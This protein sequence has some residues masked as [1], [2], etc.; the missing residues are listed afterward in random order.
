MRREEDSQ[1]FDGP[2]RRWTGDSPVDSLGPQGAAL[3]LELQ[4]L[5]RAFEG[6]NRHEPRAPKPR[7]PAADGAVHVRRPPPGR[8]KRRQKGTM[9]RAIDV[10]LE[11]FGFKAAGPPVRRNATSG[12]PAAASPRRA[13]RVA[14]AD[15]PLLMNLAE[16]GP[17]G[18]G[19]DRLML[20]ESPPLGLSRAS[21]TRKIRWAAGRKVPRRGDRRRRLYSR[22]RKSGRTGRCRR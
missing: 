10:C 21:E 3:I 4:R 16:L 1:H 22:P 11:Q 6:E 17:D 14:A 18:V 15:D 2:V 8:R 19:P 12:E 13:S 5:R 7:R 20:I 9:E